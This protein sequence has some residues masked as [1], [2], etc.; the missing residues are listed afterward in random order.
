MEPVR[1]AEA[2]QPAKGEDLVAVGTNRIVDLRK[3]L[4]GDKIIPDPVKELVW[5]RGKEAGKG[6]GADLN[7]EET[8]K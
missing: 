5:D 1:K 2:L 6:K 3:M 4:K 8:G 7:A